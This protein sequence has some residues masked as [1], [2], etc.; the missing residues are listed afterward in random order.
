M[1]S[2]LAPTRWWSTR[3]RRRGSGLA[4][5][6]QVQIT[7][8]TDDQF[9]ALSGGDRTT[10]PAG[11][12][13]AAEIVGVIRQPE[14][15]IPAA[16][17]QDA[18]LLGH[19]MVFLSPGLW[20]K[21]GPDVARFGVITELRL[22][23]GDGGVDEV[24][25][26][27]EARYADRAMVAAGAG[28]DDSIPA[29][30]DGAIRRVISLESAALFAFAALAAVVGL[31]VVGQALARQTATES[32]DDPALRAMGMTTSQTTSVA[33]LR[34]VPVAV[35][36]AAVAASLAVAASP[37]VPI[38][39][40]RRAAFDSGFRVDGPALLAGALLVVVVVLG[41]TLL[42]ARARPRHRRG[43]ARPVRVIGQLA[44]LGA[45]PTVLTGARFALQPVA[46]RGSVPTRTA[47][48]AALAAVASS[49]AAIVLVTS[50]GG[51]VDEPRRV[52]V[53]WDAVVGNS[54]RTEDT[55]RLAD[56]LR[57]LPD[58][59]AV[60]GMAEAPAQV[61]DHDLVLLSLVPVRG[62]LEPVLLDGRL[63]LSDEEVALGSETI[64]RHG[65]GIGDDVTVV[66]DDTG[67]RLT[68]R[69]VGRVVLPTSG[70]L[71]VTPGSGG[72]VHPDLLELAGGAFQSSLALRFDDDAD[73][74]AVI[75]ALKER[76]PSNVITPLAPFDVA[77]VVRLRPVAIWLA[78]AIVVLGVAALLHALIL[79]VSRRRHDLAVLAALGLPARKLGASIGW[80]AATFGVIGVVLGIPLGI[81]V[82][83]IGFR[84]LADTLGVVD[85]AELPLGAVGAVVAAVAFVTIVA[86]VG[87]AIAATRVRL[88]DALRS[89]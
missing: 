59:A 11:S 14:D 3:S 83:R 22:A 53:M 74:A 65:A 49:V 24:A 69:V 72:Y 71:E 26:A 84:A 41:L 46:S 80:Q 2:T 5:G 15:L 63:P 23:D 37:L 43:R 85:V 29:A 42:G 31:L 1:R 32:V 66:L 54:F 19:G 45:P 4:V 12:G 77:D 44:A 57:E 10:P 35:A 51:L 40:A 6:D 16:L 75:A 70:S 7:A 58:V 47:I 67:T 20:S 8:F 25:A 60:A 21:L 86:A 28:W 88:V 73:P 82:G 27:L 48:T 17:D 33:V 64:R 89:E 38:G 81:L 39:V 52:G 61:D 50:L 62:T 9:A 79:T 76:Y 55:A 13:A 36:G 34:M 68:L 87:P 30:T 56:D 78:T 18:E